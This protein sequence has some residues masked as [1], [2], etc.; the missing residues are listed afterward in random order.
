MKGAKEAME[1]AT[2]RGVLKSQLH[3]GMAML[4]EA[5]EKCP[6]DLWLSR[7][8]KN[9]FWQVAY[10]AVYF[11]HLYL[12]ASHESFQPWAGHQA[13]VQHPDGIP[14]PPDPGSSL[15]LIPQ[16]YAK[17]QVLAYWD[18]CDAM[19]DPAIDGF[20]LASPESGFPW[21]RMSKLEHQL[22]N[23]RHVQHHAAQL[24][25]RLRAALDTGVRWV[26]RRASG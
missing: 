19:V 15:P 11:T 10:H 22:V 4:R 17:A 20:D 2:M 14:G 25:D 13:E 21:Y 16:P 18:V 26:G 8:P 9:T 1:T 7:E 5:V 6:D 23:L 3:A 12:H 24:A